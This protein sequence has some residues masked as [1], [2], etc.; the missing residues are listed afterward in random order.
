M[1][2]KGRV[3][4]G[5]CK[6]LKSGLYS[7]PYEPT[8]N[9]KKI[10]SY[11]K[12]EE[13]LPWPSIHDYWYLDIVDKLEEY[14]NKYYFES[15]GQTI[16]DALLERLDAIDVTKR[17]GRPDDIYRRMPKRLKQIVNLDAD[18]KHEMKWPLVAYLWYEEEMEPEEIVQW[19]FK[20]CKWHDLND[21]DK[22]KYQVGWTC[23]KWASKVLKKGGNPVPRWVY[24]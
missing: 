16:N 2:K 10:K 18:I 8:D 1:Y 13:E 14:S 11:M 9:L 15:K 7:V 21:L 24:E 22:T 19:L 23:S 20:N 12:L 5:F 17:R 6:H 4:R 3:V